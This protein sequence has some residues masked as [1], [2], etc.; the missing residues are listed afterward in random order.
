MEVDEINWALGCLGGALAGRFLY[1]G[2]TKCFVIYPCPTYVPYSDFWEIRKETRVKRYSYP[3]ALAAA[4]HQALLLASNIRRRTASTL[5]SSPRFNSLLYFGVYK[6]GN[7]WKPNQAG[8]IEIS[9]LIDFAISNPHEAEDVFKTW[10]YVFRRGSVRGKEDLSL[11]LSEFI[12]APTLEHFEKHI[13]L[14]ARELANKVKGEFT[15]SEEA[16]KEVTSI[17]ETG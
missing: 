8:R 6:T 17:V 10:D 16:M 14:F 3:N 11:S 13:R 12:S 15:Y 2:N 7:N 4:A 5:K 1:Q 9:R